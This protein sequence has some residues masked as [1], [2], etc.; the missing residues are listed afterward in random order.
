MK[1]SQV[2]N[3]RSP[4]SAALVFEVFSPPS[5]SVVLL[6]LSSDV[7][8]DLSSVCVCAQDAAALLVSVQICFNLQLHHIHTCTPDS[9]Y[10][11][12]YL[13]MKQTSSSFL[14]GFY[15]IFSIL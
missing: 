10:S 13:Y 14:T 12:H 7:V 1:R 8:N 5:E 2:R 11:Y 6:L 15:F 3:E 4:S 9:S